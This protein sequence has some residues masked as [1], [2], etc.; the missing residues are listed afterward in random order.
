MGLRRE[1]GSA[2]GCSRWARAGVAVAAGALPLT[3]GQGVA[4]AGE[5][6]EKHA[7]V[8]WE[9]TFTSP[10]GGTATCSGSF[11]S[12][13]RGYHGWGLVWTEDPDPDCQP[14][15]V[16]V[17]IDYTNQDGGHS[18]TGAQS[19]LLFG[20]PAG[21]VTAV[22]AWDVEGDLTAEANISYWCEPGHWTDICGVSRTL[23]PK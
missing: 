23:T 21:A 22:H 20:P 1:G 7:S 13:L 8:G 19:G 17:T 2:M 14:I 6:D 5:G 11:Q 4:G 3:L 16:T 10:S 12:E 18:R 15:A 9:I